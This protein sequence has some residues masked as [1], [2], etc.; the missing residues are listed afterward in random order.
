MRSIQLIH[1]DAKDAER[2][3]D[4]LTK[5]G[6]RVEY[7]AVFEPSLLRKWRETPPGAFIFDLSRLPSH[8]REIAI[9]LRQAKATRAIPLVFCEGAPEKVEKIRA[10]LPD[11]AFCQFSKLKTTVKKALRPRTA[12]PVVPTAMMD[13]YGTRTTAQKLGVKEGSRVLVLNAPRDLEKA[14]GILPKDAAL[15][16]D[17]EA[18]VTLC[19]ATEAGELR[20]RLSALRGTAS[21]TK[22]W[23]CWKKGKGNGEV[24]EK[25]VRDTGI[26]LGLVDYKVCSVSDVWSGVLFACRSTK[27]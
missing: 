20:R 1:W 16:E 26:E 24:S 14:L 12:P 2:Y 7:S 9:S 5:A 8:C 27:E 15:I 4:L 17:G 23:V 6:Y 13:R 3:L 19:F 18:D 21:E 25:L 10:L 11:A 22:L